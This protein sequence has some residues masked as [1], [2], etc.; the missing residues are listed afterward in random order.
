M[1]TFGSLL[2]AV[3]ASLWAPP[4]GALALSRLFP[5][6]DPRIIPLVTVLWG[7]Q[8]V[9]GFVWIPV[10]AVPRPVL[11]FA[12]ANGTAAMVLLAFIMRVPTPEASLQLAHRAGYTLT[13]LALAI[14]PAL[15]LAT[16]KGAPQTS[17]LPMIALG[18]AWAVGMQLLWPHMSPV[19]WPEDHVTLARTF[20]FVPWTFVLAA[21]ALGVAIVK[22]NRG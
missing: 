11:A 13:V 5:G 18:A 12:I 3:L 4:A 1:Q 7:A 9:A 22:A 16:F 6:M 20:A 17:I 15:A 21:A 2:I 19:D 10:T 8:L 14:G